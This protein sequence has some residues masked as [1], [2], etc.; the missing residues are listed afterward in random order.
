M[1]VHLLFFLILNLPCDGSQL[2]FFF[3][4]DEKVLRVFQNYSMCE[5]KGRII[6]FSLI[7]V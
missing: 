1:Y 3:L 4:C 7:I 5:G 6:G 2:C